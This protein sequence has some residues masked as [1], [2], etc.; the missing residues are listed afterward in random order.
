MLAAGSAPSAKPAWQIMTTI[1]YFAAL[2]FATGLSM[3]L[4][5]LLPGRARDGRTEAALLALARP[6]A[7]LTALGGYF[8]YVARVAKSDV[9]ASWLQAATFTHAGDYLSLPKAEGTWIAAGVMGTLQ[10]VTFIVLAAIVWNI[11]RGQRVAVAGFWTAILAAAMPSLT[12]TLTTADLDTVADR[13]LK[14]THILATDI[15]V[16]GLVVLAAAGVIAARRRLDADAAT[17]EAGAWEQMWSRF[18]IWAMGAVIAIAVSGIWLTW[19][20]LGSFG[21]FVT[22]SYGRF[23][24]IK[25]IL[26][27]L[28]V[29]AGAYNALVLIPRIR[30]ARAAGDDRTFTRLALHHFPRIV[31]AESV[32]AFA[33]LVI[34][35]FLAGSARKQ[36]G[37][38]DAG[39]FD[40]GTFG[41]GFALIALAVAG[42]S[43]TVR[44]IERRDASLADEEEVEV[45]VAHQ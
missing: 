6:V 4:A 20:H 5:Y 13:E 39:P 17:D 12:L 22:T 9:D 1:G 37:Q 34:V 25:L 24:L 2:S 43:A 8:Q 21:Q 41:L 36:D 3:T 45:P 19:V 31:I 44:G 16:G 15:W 27:A 23:L 32:A 42:C 7:V 30:R 11:R 38:A 29:G 18:S 28:M 33:V 26:V 10:F 35:P 14:L 40:W